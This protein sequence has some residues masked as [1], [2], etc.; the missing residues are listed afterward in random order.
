MLFVELAIIRWA[1][2]NL[3]YLFAFTNVILIASFLGMG[4]GFCVQA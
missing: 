4:V 1:G 3:Y 2:A